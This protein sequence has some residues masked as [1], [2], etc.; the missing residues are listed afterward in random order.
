MGTKAI[1]PNAAFYKA[2][3]ARGQ[4]LARGTGSIIIQATFSCTH[5]SQGQSLVG[6]VVRKICGQQVVLAKGVHRE[7]CNI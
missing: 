7:I 5:G 6:D 1:R 3:E 4:V 2:I